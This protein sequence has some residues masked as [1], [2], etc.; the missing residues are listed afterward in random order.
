MGE[1]RVDLL[2]PIRVLHEHLTAALCETVFAARRVS[3]RRRI[4][5]LQRL[6]EF[7]TAVILRAPESLRQA[8]D[9]SRRGVGDW[10]HVQASPEAFFSR[11][12]GLRWEFFRD[13]FD[14]FVARVIERRRGGFEKLLRKELVAFPEVWIVDGSG[15]D[16]IAHRLKVLWDE[17]AVVLPGSL[18]VFYDLFRGLP[19]RV[20]FFAEAFGSEVVRL[21]AELASLPKGVLLVGDRAYGSVRL[22]AGLAKHGLFALVR[23]SKAVKVKRLG[24]LSRT[25]ED[26]WI[27]ED[28]LILAGSESGSVERQRLRMIR[29]RKGRKV[30]ALFTNVLDPA[31]LPAETA[32][33]LYRRRWSVERLFYDL[34]EV[35]NLRRFYAANVNAVAMQVYASALVHVALRA[36]QDDAAKHLRLAPESL[37][38]EKLFPRVAAA[39]HDLA[40]SELALVD[41]RAANPGVELRAP[42]WSTS[43]F[44]SVELSRVVVEPRKGK[45][46][47]R[48]YCASRGGHASLHKYARRTRR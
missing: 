4:W 26:G 37:S 34:K 19:R 45:R 20:S 38:V 15:L 14:A 1:K 36:C 30:L 23:R 24:V 27:T 2:G 7:W 5:T 25:Q 43:G 13:L 10:P 11:S 3:E 46:R 21:E 33:R 8:L 29:R 18:L 39:S 12:Q 16:A 41:V 6:V 22:F 17:R 28:L 35:L 31:L 40:V 9:E 48:R 47:R 42:D 44:A 32:L